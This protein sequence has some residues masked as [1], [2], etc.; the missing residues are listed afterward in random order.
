MAESAIQMTEEEIEKWIK[1]IG[2][3]WQMKRVLIQSCYLE[4]YSTYHDMNFH[5]TK[6]EAI[7]AWLKRPFK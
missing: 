1:I 4:W 7:L 2:K 3:G 6:E 5:S